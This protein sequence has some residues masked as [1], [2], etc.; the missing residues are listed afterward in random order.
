LWKTNRDIV[1]TAFVV[2]F[3]DVANSNPDEGYR[4]ISLATILTVCHSAYLFARCC[5]HVSRLAP[6]TLDH[7]RVIAE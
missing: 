4:P 3:E 5:P 7:K 2:F 6:K 1:I